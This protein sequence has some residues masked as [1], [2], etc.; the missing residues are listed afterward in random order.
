MRRLSCTLERV[1]SIVGRLAPSPTG[2]LHLGHARSF[3]L[4]WW[5]ARAAHGR[6][7][8]RI[9]D[10]DTARADGR[11]VDQARRDLE[12]LGLDWDEEHL[13]TH[14]IERLNQAVAKLIE[15]GL[16]YPCV[17][18]RGDIRRAQSA[19]HAEDFREVYPGTC[20]GRYQS[21]AE[22]ERA[23]GKPAGVRFRVPA[24]NV[25]FEDRV[26]GTFE[27]DVEREV[28]DFLIAKRDGA[29]AYQL[30][31]VVD[32]HAQGVTQVVRGDDLLDS[33]PR[34]LLLHRAF[35]FR[36]PEYAHVPLVVDDHGQRLAKRADSLSLESLRQAGVER[37][38]VLAWIAE[39]SGV[40]AGMGERKHVRQAGG[41]PADAD[42]SHGNVIDYLQG[43]DLGN[44]P[45]TPVVA[46]GLLSLKGEK[47]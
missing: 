31:V 5:A 20:R 47:A 25:R 40:I 10:L 42:F 12:W 37:Q 1:S 29:P 9:E 3:V 38:H 15:A 34:Q 23:S 8:L 11:Y 26:A 41:A 18:S 22:A 6:V 24:G 21:V 44:L 27:Q 14:T 39:S 32:D 33:T 45:R 13:Q 46:P 30:A 16:A 7:V 19:P 43:F 28:G 17:C 35:G 4:A 36:P 2:A